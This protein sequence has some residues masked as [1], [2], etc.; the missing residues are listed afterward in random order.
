MPE[1]STS[2]LPH[3]S[4]SGN[5][6]VSRVNHKNCKVRPRSL[7]PHYIKL[8]I[9]IRLPADGSGAVW[10]SRWPSWAGRPNEPSCFRGRKAILN[11]ALALISLSLS[12]YV[13]RHP[14]TLSSTTYPLIA[15]CVFWHPKV[16]FFLTDSY[17]M[18]TVSLFL[19]GQHSQPPDLTVLKLCMQCLHP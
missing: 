5:I 2:Q 18:H 3:V 17:S 6:T 7:Y 11:H 4:I 14:R 9:S 15:T 1:E 10:E 16:S 19:I 8:S 12:L 13:N